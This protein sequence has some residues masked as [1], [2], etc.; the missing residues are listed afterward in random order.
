MRPTPLNNDPRLTAPLGYG[1][2]L[3]Y[4][5]DFLGDGKPH[6][7]QAILREVRKHVHPGPTMAE[8]LI[9]LSAA[10]DAGILERIDDGFRKAQKA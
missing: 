5:Q 7:A 1:F 6:R 2:Y 9:T 3:Q 8:L 10:M 4:A